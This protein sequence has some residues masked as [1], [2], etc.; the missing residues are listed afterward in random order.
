M[1]VLRSAVRPSST[2]PDDPREME[3]HLARLDQAGL[4]QV[5]RP[6]LL[7]FRKSDVESVG[8]LT[9]EIGGIRELPSIS[10]NDD[11]MHKIR[12]KAILAVEC[13]NSL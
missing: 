3:P 9:Q 4:G 11:T 5:K 12:S 6:D 1:H 7:I 8:H 13:E 2:A 10:K